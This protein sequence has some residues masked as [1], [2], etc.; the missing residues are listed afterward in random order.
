MHFAITEDEVRELRDIDDEQERLDFFKEVI[1]PRY[2]EEERFLAESGKAWDAIHRALG[3][4]P[5]NWDGG[6]APLNQAILG[7]QSL[8]FEDDYILSLKTPQEVRELPLRCRR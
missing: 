4:G 1:E 3:D 5:L 6:E 8:Y 7:G 2:W